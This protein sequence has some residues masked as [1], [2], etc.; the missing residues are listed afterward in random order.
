MYLD[1]LAP[2]AALLG[3]QWEDDTCSFADVTLGIG[4]LQTAMRALNPAFFGQAPS[5]TIDPPRALLMPLPGAQHSFGLSMLTAFFIRGQ[6]DVWSGMAAD[7]AELRSMVQTQ[8]VDVVGFSLSCD[9]MLD[10]ARREIASVRSAS[11]N[12]AVVVMVGGPP[13]AMDPSLALSIGAD[14][15]ARDGTKAVA[16]ATKLLPRHVGRP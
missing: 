8:W 6:W 16:L 3:K 10:V 2:T 12:G 5:A 11:Q 14:G 15:T 9:A 1:L 4:V 13:F 7:S